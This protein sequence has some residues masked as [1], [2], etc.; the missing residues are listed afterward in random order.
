MERDWVVLDISEDR[1]TVS[2]SIKK[3]EGEEEPCFSPEFIESYLKENR[4]TAG[5]DRQAIE[6]LSSYVEYEKPVVVAKGKPAVNGRDGVYQYTVPL[7]DI[8]HKPVLNEDGSVDYINSLKLAMVKENDLIAVYVPATKGDYGYT[9]F[10]EMLQ[11]VPGRELRA[12]RVKNIVANDDGTEYRA[13]ITGRIFKENERIVVEKIYIVKGDLDIEQGNIV[14]NGDVEIKGDVR[15]G[16]SITA[17]GNIFIHGHVGASRLIAGG[18]VTIRKGIQGRNKC[19]IVAKGDVA[20]SFIERCTISAGGTIHADSI[21]DS[22][23]AARVK[24]N[25][26]SKKGVIVGGNVS[27]MQGIV[28]KESGNDA[29]ITTVLQAGAI[30][31]HMRAAAEM[32]NTLEAVLRDIKI[33]DEHLKKYDALDGSQ[34]TKEIE[35]TRMKILRAKV[36]KAAEQK[37]LY[38]KLTALNNEIDKAKHEA[39]IKITGTVH[40]GTQIKMGQAS[41]IVKKSCRDAEYSCENYQIVQAAGV[42]KTGVY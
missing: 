40:L 33:L 39:V 20:C 34:R 12:L 13:K 32:S 30:P 16:L 27:G 14:F 18:D 31:E 17:E 37:S 19:T 24:I 15:S 41:Y 4:I 10:S 11:P 9:V 6:A 21:M 8:K 28:A 35:A 26:N 1:M 29:G 25:V 22:D 5:I 38:E 23:V 3:P 42:Y 7:E 2:L 36:I